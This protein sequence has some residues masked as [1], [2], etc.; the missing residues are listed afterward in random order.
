MEA[1]TVAG[2]PKTQSHEFISYSLSTMSTAYLTF[3]FRE[4]KHISRVEPHQL[5]EPVCST[6]SLSCSVLPFHQ[7]AKKEDIQGEVLKLQLMN[8]VTDNRN[9]FSTLFFIHFCCFTMFLLGIA[10][11]FVGN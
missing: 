3:P 2:E 4:G 7:H 10:Y 6:K 1:V 11:C 5:V 8:Q 9:A